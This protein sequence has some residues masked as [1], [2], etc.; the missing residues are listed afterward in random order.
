MYKLIL[1]IFILINQ[2]SC[3]RISNFFRKKNCYSRISINQNNIYSDKDI[4]NKNDKFYIYIEGEKSLKAKIIKEYKS[5]KDIQNNYIKFNENTEINNDIENE[6]EFNKNTKNNDIENET[7]CNKNMENNDNDL[8]NDIEK[9]YRNKSINIPE[10]ILSLFVF[11]FLYLS[12]NSYMLG[13]QLRK[14]IDNI[15]NK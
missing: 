1:V 4:L 15:I 7:E 3:L 13:L 14:K 5:N 2:T 8:E 10:N 12:M 9:E 11:L 6:I